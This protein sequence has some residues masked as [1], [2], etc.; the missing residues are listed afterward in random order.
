M[1]EKV[2]TERRLNPAVRVG[3]AAKVGPRSKESGVVRIGL[4]GGFSITVGDRK[5]DASAW[6]LR[7][8]A[9]L[10]KLL[11]LAPGHRLHRERVM[12][13][14]WPHLGLRAAS[15]NLRQTLHVARRTL[16]PDPQIASRLLSLSGEQLALGAEERL[17]VDVEAFEEAAA[18]ARR[19]REAAAYRAAIELYSGELLPEDRYEEW[20]ESRR[21]ELR[22]TLLSLLVELA[23][24]YEA[25]GREEE[26]EPAV[27]ALQRVLAE[28]PTNEEAHVGLMRLYASSGR[29]GEALRQYE[30]LSEVL[31]GGLGGEP[32]VPARALRE[33]I[34]AAG[35]PAGPTIRPAGPPT[36]DTAG[37]GVSKHNLPAQRTNFVGKER[38]ML[39][40]KRELAM[41]RLLTLTGAGGS[42]KTRFALE[43]ARD[44]VGAYP[45]GVWLVELAPLS[46]G[47]LAPQAVADALGVPEEPGRSLADT[48]VD[49][50]REKKLLLVLD[51]CE[52]LIDAAARLA[53]AL[54]PSCPRLRVLAT[55]REALGVEGELVWQV[56]PLSVP[57]AH[58][59]GD[60]DAHRAP[61]GELA[62]YD[63][64][65]LFVERARLRSSHFELRAE[66]AGAVAQI[67]RG[68][69][70]MPLAIELAAA[71]VRVLSVE[72]ILERLADSL[73]LLR[74]ESR[75]A[76]P[77]QRTLRATLDWSHDLLSAEERVLLR[78]LSAFAGGWTLEATEAIG[79]HDGIHEEDVLDLLSNLT[80]KSL[81]VTEARAA[82]VMRYRMLEPVRQYAREKLEA[83]GEADTV[84]QLHASFFLA[85]A[86]EAKP[87]LNGPDQ[88]EWVDRLEAEHDNVRAA[89]DWSLESDPET[90]LGLVAVLGNFWWAHGHINAG[91][92][93]LEAALTRTG[94]LETVV[95]AGALRFAGVLSEEQGRYE[96]AEEFYEEGLA[97]YRRLGDRRGVAALLNSLGSLSHITGN[98]AEAMDLT[99]K[100]LSIKQELGDESGV[101]ISLNNLGAIVQTTGDLARAQTLFE[102][103]LQMARKQGDKTGAA[104]SLLNL[105]TLAVEQ[106]EPARAQALLLDALQVLRQLGDNDGVAECLDS[107]AAAAG[108]RYE[109]N[110]AARLLGAAEAARE[111]L[112]TTIHPVE[113]NMYE[114]FV[115]L[116]RCDLDEDAWSVAWAEGRAMSLEEA[117]EYA[118]SEEEF[119][120]ASSQALEQQLT[121]EQSPALTR[122]E[123]EVAALVA[124][125]LTNR[126]I[127]EEL[128]LSERTVHRHVSNVLKKLGI[129]SRE[130]VAARL[131]LGQPLNTG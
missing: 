95:R 22:R 108:K 96:W 28:E 57:A 61:A 97:L 105:G 94:G 37:G 91:S 131:A 82:E 73:K 4:L 74:S 55:S 21:G 106:D 23:G 109:G 16:H 126:R 89:L 84:R 68:L 100:S 2:G 102:E 53:D 71:R 114:G 81:V 111:T 50:L 113:R 29:S 119:T 6:R 1:G 31:S 86:K 121:H 15:N 93:W 124:R 128:F 17:W 56:D 85:L 7:K 70:G 63:A 127:A 75:S 59:D 69:E 49:A 90:A 83:S 122:R 5:V 58:R 104:I 123:E 118:M 46:E 99:E 12:D 14:L 20:A 67:C 60:R 8:A 52:H 36:E 32:S 43:V 11:A 47:K 13:L 25:R 39:E 51:N 42:G 107:L 120:T 45:D 35:V 3:N 33:E 78:R 9:S 130:Q 65:R 77:R 27:Q 41:T 54:L 72:Q 117:I 18:T 26:L 110:R 34:A 125:G 92:R 30:R 115:N 88:A 19:S 116:S 101:A 48:L 87:E 10:V 38:E 40:V 76:T 44:L 24:L 112:G 103:S 129:A 62:R 79:A 64:V 66:N 98:Q 80:D